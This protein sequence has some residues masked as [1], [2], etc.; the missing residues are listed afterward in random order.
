M[1]RPRERRLDDYG[2]GNRPRWGRGRQGRA[3]L[4]SHQAGATEYIDADL[5]DT[6]MI[7]TQAARLL[8][9]TK[10]VAVTLLMILHVIP[11][12]DDPHALVARVMDAM[13]SGSY[14]VA[15]HLGAELLEQ[16]AKQGLAS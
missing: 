13:P 6:D 3:L 2:R 8:D 14:L 15:S 1:T 9:F 11:D 12:S 4:T 5:R 10:P 7:L 16:E